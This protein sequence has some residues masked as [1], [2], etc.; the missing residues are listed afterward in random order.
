MGNCCQAEQQK[1]DVYIFNQGLNSPVANVNRQLTIVSSLKRT[2]TIQKKGGSITR[3][4][5]GIQINSNIIVEKKE[6]SPFDFYT[7]ERK[8]GDGSFGEVY[9]VKHKKL[10]IIRAMKKISRVKKSSESEKDGKCNEY[11]YRDSGTKFISGN[12]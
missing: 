5:T 4:T 3:N 9:K 11:T 2:S 8:L 6:C 1:N 12:Y 7:I 10:G